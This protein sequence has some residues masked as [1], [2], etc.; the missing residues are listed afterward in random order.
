M[1]VIYGKDN[2]PHCVTAQKLCASNKIEFEYKSLNKDYDNDDVKSLIEK[3]NQRTFPFIFQGEEFI[4]GAKELHLK[5]K[6][7]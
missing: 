7:S 5:L 4:G 2:C 1:I 3:T 6:R